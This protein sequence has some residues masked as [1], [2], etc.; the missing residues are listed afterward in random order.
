[1][2]PESIAGRYRVVRP[3][4]R[5]GMGTVWLCTDEVLHRDVAVK[6]V[7]SFPGEDPSDTA[8][9]LREARLAAA[10]NHK[11][12][13]AIYDVVEHDGSTWLV[14]EYFPSQTLSQLI[15]QEGRLPP[16]RAAHLGAQ[17]AAALS[18]AHALGI[19]HRDIKPG[20]ILVGADDAAKIS[21]FGIARG[22]Q[23]LRLTQTGMVTGTP[24]F[25]SP[26]LARG[27]EP[28][29]ES[30]VWALGITLHTAVEG[31]PP[32]RADTNPLAV[33]AAIVHEPLPAPVHAGPL[34]GALAGMLDPDPNR[35]MT[36]SQ[37]ATAL[38]DVA[39]SSGYIDNRAFGAPSPATSQI[40]PVAPPASQLSVE[41]AYEQPVVVPV[42][43]Y[44]EPLEPYDGQP[45]N[46]RGPSWLTR[47]AV[48]LLGLLVLVGG[49]A[50]LWDTLAGDT[51][52]ASQSSAGAAQGK[53][54][55]GTKQPGVSTQSDQP[56][57]S[58]SPPSSDPT[59][60]DTPSSDA[61]STDEPST[62]DPSTDEPSRHPHGP[63]TGDPESFTL[64]YF[65][66]VPSNTQAGWQLLTPSFRQRLTRDYYDSFWGSVESVDVSNVQTLDAETVQYDIV[67]SFDDGTQ[68]PETKQLTLQ[69]VGSSYRIVSDTSAG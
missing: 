43:S 44:Q 3:V 19:V 61:P 10:L 25:F 20:N 11:N 29:F 2:P 8:R 24:A 59:S 46:S 68:S 69:P 15:K 52:G 12:A 63:T 30:D 31:E 41:P 45:A 34:R 16:S 60:V 27:E 47:T 64:A 22:Q 13:T 58:N 32:Y 35:R 36:M 39:V 6:Q 5:G 33:L 49:G 9:A 48:A 65:A 28:T 1:M 37:A 14:M 38:E 55:R 56:S 40:P 62:D 67:Y 42:A 7:G 23:D 17:V 21:D 53:P 18:A 51:G 54:G 26:E 66:T 4:G 57:A 50:L